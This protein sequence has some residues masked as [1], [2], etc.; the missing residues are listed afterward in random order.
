MILSWESIEKLRKLRF[1]RVREIDPPPVKKETTAK[2]S[3]PR[4]SPEK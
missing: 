2:G 3:G 4:G 1:P